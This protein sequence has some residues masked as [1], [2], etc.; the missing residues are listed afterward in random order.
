V[1]AITGEIPEEIPRSFRVLDMY[2]ETIH[3]FNVDEFDAEFC[4]R[5]ANEIIP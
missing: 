4:K 2:G 1:R 5:I 3:L